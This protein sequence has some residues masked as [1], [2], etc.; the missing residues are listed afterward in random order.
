MK[1]TLLRFEID[2]RP[3]RLILAMRLLHTTNLTVEEFIDE[4][5]PRYAILSHT[6]ED[7]EITLQDIETGRA[8]GKEGYTKVKDCCTYARDKDRFAYVWIDTCCI[9]KTSSAE[10]S[11][12]INSMYRWYQEADICYAFLA[13]VS[14]EGSMAESKWFTRGWTLQE[15]IAPTHLLFLNRA[16]KELGSKST[17]SDE[18]AH[19]TGIPVNVLKG[20]VDIETVSIAQRMSWASSRRTTRPED[21]AYCLMGL[22]GINMPLIYGEG[23][24]AFTRLQEEIM[25][26]SDDYSIFAWWT[27][28]QDESHGGLLAT[29]PHAF[30]NSASILPS[31]DA[32]SSSSQQPHDQLAVSS[33]G[34]HLEVPFLPVGYDGLGFA[35]LNCAPQDQTNLVMAIY[36]RDV[37]LTQRN[38]QRVWP[39]RL[40]TVDLSRYRPAQHPLTRI[41]IRQPRLHKRR[42]PEAG[43]AALAVN[44]EVREFIGSFDDVEFNSLGT[45]SIIFEAAKKGDMVS[46]E[47]YVTASIADGLDETGRTP[48]SHAAEQGRE[49]ATWFFLMWRTVKADSRDDWG[50]TPLSYAAESGHSGVVWLLLMRSDVST[51]SVSTDGLTPL[52]YAARAGHY[53]VLNMILDRTRT[54]Q[55]LYDDK[56][57]TPLS[58]A[59]ENG[60]GEIVHALLR[61]GDM[62]PDAADNEGKT[63][64]YW[65][66]AGRQEAMAAILLSNGA[67]KEATFGDR[68]TELSSNTSGLQLLWWA[69]E[70]RHLDILSIILTCGVDADI[71]RTGGE[72]TTTTM[73]VSAAQNGDYEFAHV[74]L[75]HRPNMYAKDATGNTPLTIAIM[76]KDVEFVELMLQ[77]GPDIHPSDEKGFKPIHLAVQS[78]VLIIAELLLQSDAHVDALASNGSTPLT[79]AI[80]YRDC[81]MVRLLLDNGADCEKEDTRGKTPLRRA[82]DLD[83]VDIVI[84]LLEYGANAAAKA[85]AGSRAPGEELILYAVSNRKSDSNVELTR[86]LLEHGANVEAASVFG[87]TPLLWAAKCGDY[88]MILLLLSFGA[89]LEATNNMLQTPLFCAAQEGQADAVKLLLSHGA[90]VDHQDAKGVSVLTAAVK[91]KDGPTVK[92]LRPS[93][94]DTA[95]SRLLGDARHSVDKLRTISGFSKS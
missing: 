26:I 89:D 18:V 1:L 72:S 33:K 75:K 20:I 80:D 13:D 6:W 71:I 14:L 52:S 56:R 21:Q 36:V 23:R 44:K 34:V 22:F 5:T 90:N 73:L 2:W 24:R 59:C 74:L 42:Y 37:S 51:Y 29:S 83:C 4:N 11:E 19:R 88:D 3:E 58:Y 39:D 32:H 54:R 81:D 69:F 64:L 76:R 86:I 70:G 46:L 77:H 35:I 30:K 85:S 48:L 50:R 61:R 94:K 15:L 43:Q 78:G 95:A 57:R 92:L 8:E 66:I 55:E 40:G 16:W 9:D 82:V 27:E 60:H 28:S 79:I 31:Q 87:Q 91:S 47:D 53:A 45:P 17:L 93:T 63:P 10:L 84:L 25:R 41:I 67:N 65:A 12:A 38:F 49:N 62:E 68:K 7:G